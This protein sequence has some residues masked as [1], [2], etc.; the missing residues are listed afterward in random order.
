MFKRLIACRFVLLVW[1]DALLLVVSAFV[2]TAR[3]K[4][5][6]AWS[7]SGCGKRGRRAGCSEWIGRRALE[8]QHGL[9][10]SKGGSRRLS[11]KQLGLAGGGLIAGMFGVPRVRLSTKTGRKEETA[12]RTAQYFQARSISGDSQAQAAGPAYDPDMPLSKMARGEQEAALEWM[13][14]RTI[15]GEWRMLTRMQGEVDRKIGKLLFRG[16]E[17]E[18]NRGIVEYEG[19]DGVTGKGRWTLKPFRMFNLRANFK[20]KF[21]DGSSFLYRGVVINN[22]RELE[23]ERRL[24]PFMSGDVRLPQTG[25]VAAVLDSYK[26]GEFQAEPI[27]FFDSQE[28]I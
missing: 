15:R 20:L 16:F 26:V 11:L 19:D 2:F 10:E 25:A 7:A 17:D 27:K 1:S 8:P 24:K 3:R 5:A 13:A 18:W 28:K 6:P 4:A 14:V 22:V 21:S 23:R 9:L 12:I